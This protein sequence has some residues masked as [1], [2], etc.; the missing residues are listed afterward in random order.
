MPHPHRIVCVS[1]LLCSGC[2]V[3]IAESGKDLSTLKTRE[4]VHKQFGEPVASGTTND[5]SFEVYHTHQKIADQADADYL[6]MGIAMTY[7]VGELVAFPCE[8]YLL[9]RNTIIGRD[10]RF[11]YDSSGK[12]TSCPKKGYP[13]SPSLDRPSPEKSESSSNP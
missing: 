11:T 6:S 9:G 4:Q 2:S 7:G 10:I 1:V 12:V 5:E 13:P 3:L 8:L